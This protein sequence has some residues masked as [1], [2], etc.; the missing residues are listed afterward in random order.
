MAAPSAVDDAAAVLTPPLDPVSVVSDGPASVVTQAGAEGAGDGVDALITSG[1]LGQEN[2]LKLTHDSLDSAVWSDLVTR[3]GTG[4]TVV[5][6]GTT[7]DVFEGKRVI[8]LEYEA[9][10]PMALKE[11]ERLCVDAR[12]LWPALGPIAIVHRLGLVPVRCVTCVCHAFTR[13]TL[14]LCASNCVVCISVVCVCAAC[15]CVYV[16]WW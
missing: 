2:Y 10:A 5:F 1:A 14:T 4:A 9:Y 11:L 6:I 12:A 15:A 16:W 13:I 3:D 8:R 7:R